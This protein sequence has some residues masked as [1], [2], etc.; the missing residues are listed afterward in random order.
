[1]KFFKQFYDE[2][3]SKLSIYI[4]KTALMI[5]VMGLVIF[6]FSSEA[7]NIFDFIKAVL[8]PLVLGLVLAYLLTP[9]VEF[10]Q[11][12]VLYNITDEKK[13]RSLAVLITF[14]MI[15][16]F[17][18]LLLL[19][20]IM[21][22]TRSID[23]IE[24]N[25]LAAFVE[26]AMAEFSSFWKSVED[27]LAQFN[28]DLGNIGKILHDVFN[29]VSAGLSNLLFANIFAIYFLLDSHI[30]E[31]W[32]NVANVLLTEETRVK[33]AEFAKDADRVFSGYIRG[34]SIDAFMV[35]ALVTVAL[36]ILG[37]PYAIVIGL[38]TGLGNLIPYVGP[39]IGFASLAIVAISEGSMFHLLAGG[40]VLAIV[41]AIDGN[42]INPKLLS[43]NVE[44]HP[45]LVII[46]LIA[47]GN[48]GGV[49]GMLLAVPVAA[50]L[51]L[52]F[53][54]FI[55]RKKLE[56]EQEKKSAAAKAKTKTKSKTKK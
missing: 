12:R 10:F 56:K 14:G 31:Y 51:K 7:K 8:G 6:Y 13:N 26:R 45:I 52:Q 3:Y 32:N 49:A 43:D 2:K 34:Q 54:K 48:I 37:V 44:V 20:L 50:L 39:I 53:D 33:M 17:I 11:N 41:M 4:M 23:K 55:E 46:A 18:I 22:V 40:A 19:A 36:L 25:D 42:I 30:D 1:M 16:V 35:G 24:I 27:Q 9:V 29:N 21:T 47:G 38:L 15:A 5:F 28:I